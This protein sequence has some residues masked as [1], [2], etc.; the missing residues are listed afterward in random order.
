MAFDNALAGAVVDSGLVADLDPLPD[1]L[2]GRV[3][4]L[5][6]ALHR[7]TAAGGDGR[8][9]LVPLRVNLKLGFYRKG[10]LRRPGTPRIAVG[11]GGAGAGS[12]GADG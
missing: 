9:R 2:G 3:G 12:P 4:P 7:L 5:V 6:P 1:G 11:G 10:S 8:V